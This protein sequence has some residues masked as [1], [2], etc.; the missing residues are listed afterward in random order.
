MKR[1]LAALTVIAATCLVV[2]ATAGAI[3]AGQVCPAFK[4]GRFTYR[5]QTVGRWSC[6][7]AQ[8]W[9]AKLSKDRA[10][11]VSKNIPLKNGPRGPHCWAVVGSHGHVTSGRCIKG[12]L[13][14]PKTGFAWFT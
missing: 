10:Q 3:R 2:S 5:S 8:S 14:F 12:T 1:S 6:G 7:S 13:A 4:Q 9:I 11:V